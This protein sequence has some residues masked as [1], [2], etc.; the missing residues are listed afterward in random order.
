M[1]M[2]RIE[3]KIKTIEEL[4]IELESI[5]PKNF[6]EFINSIKTKRACYNLFETI[7]EASNDLAILIIKKKQLPLPNSDEKAFD[8]LE[9]A[10]IISGKLA[11][12]L[13]KAKGM[14]NYIVHQ[15]E[16]IDNKIVYKA[17][18]QEIIKDSKEFLGAI[19]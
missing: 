1:N 13:K 8:I 16:T 17:V 11:E 18:T 10:T 15:Y 3:D 6:D 7:I 14:R 9:K 4:I 5:M 12:K 2:G 19:K